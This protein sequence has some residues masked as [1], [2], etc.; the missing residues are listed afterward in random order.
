[1]ANITTTG[2][3]TEGVAVTVNTDLK[4]AALYVGTGG[5]ITVEMSSGQSV[6]FKNVPDGTFLPI[7]VSKVTAVANG[8][9]V[10]DI[11]ALG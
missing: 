1:M 10:G 7:A 11:I 3:A 6:T 4:G 8:A 9:I 2:F 5:D